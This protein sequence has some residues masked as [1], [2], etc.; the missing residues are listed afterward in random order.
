MNDQPIQP[1]TP[2]L[3][4]ENAPPAEGKELQPRRNLLYDRVADWTLVRTRADRR[5]YLPQFR[6]KMAATESQTTA[7]LSASPRSP[8]AK[9]SRRILQL[10]ER[11]GVRLFRCTHRRSG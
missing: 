8:V 4:E 3:A 7:E 11:L 10:E 2:G 9:L 6:R 1:C 5:D